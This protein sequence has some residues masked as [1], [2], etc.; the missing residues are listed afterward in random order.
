MNS[1][2]DESFSSTLNAATIVRANPQNVSLNL[3]F[4][5]GVSTIAIAL[6]AFGRSQWGGGM[7][8][9]D[10]TLFCGEV[11]GL[12]VVAFN[13]VGSSQ[14]QHFERA[15]MRQ[16]G[17]TLG[18]TAAVELLATAIEESFKI[19]SQNSRLWLVSAGFTA[20]YSVAALLLYF[21]APTAPEAEQFNPILS[22]GNSTVSGGSGLGSD[23]ETGVSKSFGSD[24]T[25]ALL[26]ERGVNDRSKNAE[27]SAA[28]S[29]CT[30]M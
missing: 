22:A 16:G 13:V 20:G 4:N 12:A 1:R 18:L 25:T 26:R 15:T 24:V 27:R 8:I 5:V 3:A 30:V 9:Y 17:A 6:Y 29:A 11:A 28:W 10:P 21:R 2:M 14:H 23:E 7:S 19:T